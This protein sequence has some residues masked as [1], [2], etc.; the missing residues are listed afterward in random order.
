M[1]LNI[2]DSI[3]WLYH[4]FELLPNIVLNFK[5]KFLYHISILNLYYYKHLK[6]EDSI[7]W[8]YHTFEW[9]PHVVLNY[10]E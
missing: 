7:V 4:T 3:V 10:Q 6:I 2:E 5:E 8:L 1:P 9:L